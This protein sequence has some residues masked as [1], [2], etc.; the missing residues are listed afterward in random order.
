MFVSQ[1]VTKKNYCFIPDLGTYSGV[2]T[3]EMLCDKWGITGEEWAYI[4]ARITAV[5]SEERE[6][7]E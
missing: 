1:D 5:G 3:D 4:D 2:Y 7:N 6:Q